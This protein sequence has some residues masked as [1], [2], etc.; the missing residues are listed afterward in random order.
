MKRDAPATHRNREPLREVLAGVLPDGLVLEVASGT[1]QHARFFAEAF[2]KLQWQPTDPDEVSR[3][4]IAAWRDDSGP[5]NLLAPLELDATSQQ[6]PIDS[7]DAVVCINMIH[8]SP[9]EA[10]A[11]LMRG[12]ARLLAPGAPL[13][14]YGPYRI[15]GEHT[16]P[17]NEQFDASLKSRDPR[18]GIRDIDELRFLA[19]L[20]GFKLEA[21]H[22]M[23]ANNFT[24]IWRRTSR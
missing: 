22:E 14:T 6:W 11:G 20:H 12:A 8:I 10:S 15:D 9:I 18:W 1:G 2:P 17:S 4:S 23:P 7:C 16:A 5:A 13:V 19:T 21:K 24:L 3:A